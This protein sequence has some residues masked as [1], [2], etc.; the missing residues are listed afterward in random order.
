MRANESE[1]RLL[2][3]MPTT[4]DAERTVTVFS[5]SDIACRVCTDLFILCREL[6]A[7]AGAALLTEEAIFRDK[8]GCL[9]QTLRDEPSWSNFPLI[10][11]T[12]QGQRSQRLMGHPALNIT[13]VERPVRMTTLRSV[14]EAALRHRRHQYA[15]RDMLSDLAEQTEALRASEERFRALVSQATA[16]IAQVDRAGRFLF[17]NERFC[18]IAGFSE[19]ELLQRRMQDLTHSED[20]ER[21]V[22]QFMT[23][24]QGGP[25]FTIEKRYLRKNGSIVWVSNSVAA[26]RGPNEELQS[27]V[28]VTLD[29][30]ER[31]KAQD[32]IQALNQ[33]L[34]RKIQDRT[35]KLQETIT[36]LEAFSYSIS[37]DLRAPLRAMHGY[38]E[39]LI[40]EHSDK[41]GEDGRHYL[42]RIHRGATR[43]D[44][45][46][47][48]VLAYS[49]IAKGEVQLKAI[50]LGGM[51]DEVILGYPNLLEK[52][53]ISVEQPL[54]C[55]IA[56]EAY[57]TQCISNLLGNAV[58]FVAPGVAPKVRLWAE[59][60]GQV[61]RVWFE[62]NG[63]GIAPEHHKQ[64]F[65]IFGR[66]Y[67]DKQFEGTGIGL[68][69]VKKAA[70]RMG[71]EAGVVS[72]IGCGSRFWLSLKKA[73]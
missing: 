56:H 63:I 11:L 69:I 26:V 45:L 32:E 14:V 16:G 64:I 20:V 65:Q 38:A 4:K 37:H 40:E 71:G 15:I 36:E 58:K 50:P 60:N 47:Q 5:K 52:A 25:D 42:E 53:E 19:A 17:V 68:A 35:A 66:V 10:V 22:T 7:G 6:S 8:T 18:E 61:V 43:L 24:V 9:S 67:S 41:V 27:V 34:E 72:E 46:V 12:Q 54:P 55:V 29:I 39:A 13:L 62:D 1:E 28:A 30:T 49:K 73:I 57:L 3:L 59:I 44:L 23:L 33:D 31:R 2:V 21:N 51:I 48:D 70:E